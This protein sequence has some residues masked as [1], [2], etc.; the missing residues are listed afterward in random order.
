MKKYVAVVGVDGDLKPQSGST[1]QSAME[2]AL[3][4]LKREQSSAAS[5]VSVQVAVS[6]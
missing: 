1:E 3:E 4:L 2:I 6:R 5:H